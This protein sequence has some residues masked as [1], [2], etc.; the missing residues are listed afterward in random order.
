MERFR[1]VALA[2]ALAAL[3]MA[4]PAA[5]SDAG[6][7]QAYIK[8]NYVFTQ[9]AHSHL[10]ASK[11]ALTGMLHRIGQECP[12]AAKG[13]PQN[14][15]SEH[16]S[17]E[18]IGLLVLEADKPDR[19]AAH[20]FL[21]EVAS[22]RWSNP[23]LNRKLHTYFK[24]I[25]ALDK[26]SPPDVCADVRTWVA[27][28]STTIPPSTVAFDDAFLPNWVV[29]GYQPSG[30]SRFESGATRALARRTRPLE[31]KLQEFEAAETTVGTW[32][33][34]LNVLELGP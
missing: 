8:A 32:A 11:R 9:A 7:T 5:A 14:V 30:L 27:G 3:A 15:Q 4:A 24:Q 12:R 29:A 2:S 10:G 22:L 26:L 28:G 20:R 17:N 31:D 1:F 19:A 13:T 16:L 33:E 23:S 25:S 34:V 18:V 21:R 6:V